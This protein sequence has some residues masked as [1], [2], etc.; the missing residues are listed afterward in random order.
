MTTSRINAY[1]WPARLV[2]HKPFA[3]EKYFITSSSIWQVFFAENYDFSFFIFSVL[4]MAAFSVQ[5]AQSQ[6]FLPVEN[7]PVPLCSISMDGKGG[8]YTYIQGNSLSHRCAMPAPSRREPLAWREGFRLKCKATCPGNTP[9]VCSLRSQPPSPRGRLS[10]WRQAFRHCQK[11]SPWGNCRRRRLRG[12]LSREN[13]LPERPQ[14][15]RQSEIIKFSSAE[16]AQSN[17]ARSSN[18]FF[19]SCSSSPSRGVM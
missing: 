14:T 3:A 13:G 7:S 12:C 6:R 15:L 19:F 18:H 10:W 2:S 8:G 9:S 4:S 5:D 17:A 16:D 1:R 11:A